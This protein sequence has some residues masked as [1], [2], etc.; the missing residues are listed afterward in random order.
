MHLFCVKKKERNLWDILIFQ[1]FISSKLF[2][3]F[4][5]THLN[6]L[7]FYQSEPYISNY[8][9]QYLQLYNT[10]IQLFNTNYLIFVYF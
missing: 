1:F 5:E 10:I 3:I 8:L 2:Q 6:P 4:K 7:D 9:I